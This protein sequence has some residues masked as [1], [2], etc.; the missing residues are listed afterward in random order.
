[1]AQVQDVIV[2]GGGIVGM[3]TAR[4]LADEGHSV[5]LVERDRVGRGASRA[6]G[7]I[8]SSLVPWESPPAL[9]DMMAV[10][11]EILPELA[12]QLENDTGID[13]E[14]RRTGMLFLECENL[15]AAVAWAEAAGVAHRVLE[16]AD[17]PTFEPAAARVEG[18]S[19][20]LPDRAQVRN[21][22]LLDALAKDLASRGVRILERA[23]DAAIATAGA[24]LAVT[25]PAHGRLVSAEVVLAAGAWSGVLAKDLGLEL[26][27]VPIRGQMIWFQVPAAGIRRMILRNRKYVVPREEGVVLCGS[28]LEEV[29]FD[30]RITEAAREEL[31]AAA[32]AIAP[33]LGATT[34]QGQWAGLR[35][36]A[37]DNVPFVGAAPGVPGLWLATGHARNG[38]NLAAGSARLL[39][40]LM[41]GRKPCLDPAPY[42]PGRRLVL[43]NESNYNATH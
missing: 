3:L 26:P 10:S 43:E 19:L 33:I 40:D 5:T 7:G 34:I 30:D 38:L 2:V 42:D 14:F 17:V 36:G 4:R 20:L 11:M 35:P 16:P 9:A 1:M 39:A 29:G 27:I 21:T 22:R 37:P 31:A 41:A 18:R 32:A 12:T 23:G 6:A 8:L 24:G 25:T 15:D 13:C 28:T